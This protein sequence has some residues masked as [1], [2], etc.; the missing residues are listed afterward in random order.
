[1]RDCKVKVEQGSGHKLNVNHVQADRRDAVDTPSVDV[2]AEV[3]KAAEVYSMA[4]TALVSQT[5]IEGVLWPSTSQP[6]HAVWLPTDVEGLELKV[7]P[8]QYIDVVINGAIHRALIDSGAQISVIKQ[9][10]VSSIS[11]IRQVQLHGVV[12]KSVTKP[13]IA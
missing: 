12:G 10:V 1:M 13:L 3:S 4:D 9:S 7:S 8:L 2:G 6:E 11:P 5:N